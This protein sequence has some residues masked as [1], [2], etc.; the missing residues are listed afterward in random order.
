M[1]V[2][3]TV[4]ARLLLL[5][6]YLLFLLA[7]VAAAGATIT[8]G[9]LTLTLNRQ[10]IITGLTDPDGTDYR[11]A[12]Q[13]RALVS[14]IVES[15]TTAR[16]SSVRAS[17]Y[18]PT[19]W[20]YTAGTPLSGETAR[21]E[22]T[23]RF[24]DNISVVVTRVEKAGYATLALQTVTN[25]NGKDIRF[26]LWGPLATTLTEHVADKA[27]VVSN[28]DFAIGMLGVNAKTRGRLAAGLPGSG[29][30]RGG[31][32]ERPACR[33]PAGSACGS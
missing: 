17:H 33:T 21:G 23:F 9:D 6:L 11:A 19:G 7:S 28:R 18:N 24:R 31:G 29:L 16:P 8:A 14:L 12:G 20:T 1:A 22:Y 30:C 27:G 25:P 26:V 2:R 10:G 32:R 15:A 3:R 4:P 5:S 13:A